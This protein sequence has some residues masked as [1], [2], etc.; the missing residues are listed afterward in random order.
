[1]TD[2]NDIQILEPGQDGFSFGDKAEFSHQLCVFKS[3]SR[4]QDCLAQE[5]REGFSET[6]QDPAGNIM[7]IIHPDSRRQAVEA[8]MTLKNVMI[9]DIKDSDYE[10]N[11]IELVK[12]GDGL[13]DEEL[14][15]QKEFYNSF[16]NHNKGPVIDYLPFVKSKTLFDKGPFYHSYLIKLVFVYR[17]IFE[18]LELCLSKFKYYKKA[19]IGN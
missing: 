11:I 2:D 14:N 5:M 9:A 15:K 18:Q 7:T 3:F 6:K 8:V 1:M 4:T 12:E 17:Q 10:E 13:Y 19:K 16:P